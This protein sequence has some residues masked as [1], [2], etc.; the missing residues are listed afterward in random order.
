MNSNSALFLSFVVHKLGV[1]ELKY[2][3]ENISRKGSDAWFQDE[4]AR[5]SAEHKVPC[6]E[7]HDIS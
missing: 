7:A 5:F 3:R 2:L 4:Y 1:V 6:V